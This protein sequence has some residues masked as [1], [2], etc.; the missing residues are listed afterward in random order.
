MTNETDELL[1]QDEIEKSDTRLKREPKD[2]LVKMINRLGGDI[3]EGD[4][5]TKDDVAELAVT[6]RAEYLA[7]LKAVASG[8]QPEPTPDYEEQVVASGTTEHIDELAAPDESDDDIDFIEAE[9]VN[10]QLRY[11]PDEP[12]HV[13]RYQTVIA[14]KEATMLKELRRTRKALESIAAILQDK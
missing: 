1:S 7:G 13:L 12:K 2:K 8:E 4:G 10:A 6:L 9:L 5:L 11:N 3:G 14:A